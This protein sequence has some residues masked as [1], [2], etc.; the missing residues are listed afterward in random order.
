[1]TFDLSHMQ[2]ALSLA[3]EA[4]DSNEVPVGAVLVHR[5][6]GKQ[7]AASFNHMHKD[8]NPLFHA[9]ILII[10]DAI[11]TLHIKYLTEYD[12]YVTLEPCLMC[13]GAISHSR[14]GRLFYAASDPK[15]GAIENG[16]RVYSGNQCGYKP[17]IY[18]GI[19]EEESR[20]IL[21][22]FFEGLR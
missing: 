1:M 14:I 6:S 11:K 4:F 9:E 20:L 7:I 22:K 8:N 21:K 5:K 17:E 16:A 13:A 12:L 2:S 19:M 3:K 15:F 18:S 10:Q